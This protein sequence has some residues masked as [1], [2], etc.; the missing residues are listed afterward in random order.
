MKRKTDVKTFF[1][2]LAILALLANNSQNCWMVH[3]A[4]F[5]Q[6]VA[7][8]CVLLGVLA[9]SFKPVKL[10]APS[11]RAQHC[12]ELLHPFVRSVRIDRIKA[13]SRSF[14]EGKKSRSSLFILENR[15]RRM[16]RYLDRYLVLAEIGQHNQR[17]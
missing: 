17:S 13:M 6:P 3:A 14:T 8:C 4:S 16:F 1:T 11:K 5:A 10:S 9:Q 15:K 7:C 12:W 2:I